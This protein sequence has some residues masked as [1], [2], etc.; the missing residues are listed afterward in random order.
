MFAWIRRLR[1]WIRYRKF[2]EDVRQE[3]DVHRAMLHDDLVR[4]GLGLTEARSAAGDEFEDAGLLRTL[5]RCRHL[6]SQSMVDALFNDVA[7]FAGGHLQ[8]DAT[9]VIA[10]IE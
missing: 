8:D 3:I 6:D 4:G 9:A 1:A 2:D 5:E 10:A 7:S